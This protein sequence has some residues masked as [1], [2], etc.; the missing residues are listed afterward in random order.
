MPLLPSTPGAQTASLSLSRGPIQ[1][2]PSLS[3]SRDDGVVNREFTF[4]TFHLVGAP[5]GRRG[6]ALKKSCVERRVGGRMPGRETL[7]SEGC[8]TSPLRRNREQ[9]PR[10]FT[11]LLR[12][13]PPIT[14]LDPVFQQI[15]AFR[16]A[17]PQDL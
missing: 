12:A 3:P 16:R 10:H 2:S 5:P 13:Y 6:E 4:R 15:V 17:Y 9:P 14:S 8:E 7:L 11:T 1:T